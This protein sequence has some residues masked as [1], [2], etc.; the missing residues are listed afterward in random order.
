MWGK[1]RRAN[2][3]DTQVTATCSKPASCGFRSKLVA[4]SVA[5]LRFSPLPLTNPSPE[6]SAL[7]ERSGSSQYFLLL[8]TSGKSTNT[9]LPAHL[10][11]RPPLGGRLG[12][13][14]PWETHR[15]PGRCNREEKRNKKQNVN[16]GATTQVTCFP[17][18]CQRPAAP[19]QAPSLPA[20]P[21]K[22]P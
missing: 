17:A 10:P 1:A 7:L 5:S 21:G 12:S 14:Q 18:G 9:T 22:E 15:H 11:Q 13:Y 4:P 19:C 6:I 8:P 20:S 16:A 2:F 3:Q